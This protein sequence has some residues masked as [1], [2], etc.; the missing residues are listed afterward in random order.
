VSD[1]E[2]LLLGYLLLAAAKCCCT[3][4]TSAEER[5]RQRFGDDVAS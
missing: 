2:Y 5:E 1:R 3:G 4:K